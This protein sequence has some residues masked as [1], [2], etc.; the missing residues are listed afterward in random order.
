M[1]PHIF[2]RFT[3]HNHATGIVWDQFIPY[4]PNEHQLKIMKEDLMFTDLLGD[5]M[6]ISHRSKSINCSYELNDN[7]LA[8][9]EVDALIEHGRSGHFYFYKKINGLLQYT[10]HLNELLYTKYAGMLRYC[11]HDILEHK[12]FENLFVQP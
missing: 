7:L 3:E 1:S 11:V 4:Y 9:Y 10:K 5:A 2:M 8:E 6:T 12:N